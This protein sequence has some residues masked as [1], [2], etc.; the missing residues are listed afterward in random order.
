MF[1]VESKIEERK[2][3]VNEIEDE[4]QNEAP[5]K[6]EVAEAVESLKSF[7]AA[8]RTKSWLKS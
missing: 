2:D 7:K 3:D 6:K 5:T 4:Q 1:N 8:A